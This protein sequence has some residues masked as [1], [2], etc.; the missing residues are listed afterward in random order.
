MLKT[1][2]IYAG[3]YADLQKRYKRVQP[4]YIQNKTK[5][6][7]MPSSTIA[8]QMEELVKNKQALG[9]VSYCKV[10]EHKEDPIVELVSE[11]VMIEDVFQVNNKWVQQ[12]PTA[13]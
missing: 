10:K 9:M 4:S 1:Y 8:S 2:K 12:N 5:Y 7:D 11:F 3:C 6:F 13:Q